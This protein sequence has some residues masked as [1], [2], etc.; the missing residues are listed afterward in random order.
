MRLPLVLLISSLLAC[1]A[2]DV[3]PKTTPPAPPPDDVPP[4]AAASPS[5]T[6]EAEPAPEPAAPEE[7]AARLAERLIDNENLVLYD[8]AGSLVYADSWQQEGTGIGVKVERRH[9]D[10]TTVLVEIGPE[11][12][13]EEEQEAAVAQLRAAL[14]GHHWR[15]LERHP[16]ED[17]T[18]P[19][20]LPRLGLT[21]D[22]APPQ[23]RLVGPRG[24][25]SLTIPKPRATP[26]RPSP[27][28][29]FALAGVPVVVVLVWFDAGEHYGEGFNNFSEH[30]LLPID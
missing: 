3:A 23:L 2:P 10:A 26:H 1:A 21:L 12:P 16:W 11:A 24:E 28:T 13:S 15:L 4:A 9:G 8:S 25:R 22:Y 5:A 17:P 29:V 6:T 14:E 18:R 20:E 27:S 7:P 30:H 19:L